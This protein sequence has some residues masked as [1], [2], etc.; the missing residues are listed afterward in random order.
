MKSETCS[1]CGEEIRFGT[2]GNT[3][4]WLHRGTVDHAAILGRIMTADDVADVERQMDLPRT[5]MVVKDGIEVE[6]TYTAREFDLAR[7]RKS[8]K[9]REA[10]D[11]PDEPADLLP[12]VEIECH[13]LTPADLPPRSGCRQV[14]NLVNKT[15]G[16]ELISLNHS[17]GPYI[18]TGG[19]VL[20]ISDRVLLKARG[21]VRFD[22]YVSI[23]VA[24]WR[25]G[26][27]DS[28]YIGRAQGGDIAV[29]AA[30]AT[31]LKDWIKT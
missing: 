31:E 20:S 19:K 7:Y 10:E 28:A 27:F 29:S 8:K 22:G 5:R 23:A 11:E 14:V 12:P 24:S 16:W 30:N 9:Y 2:R 21:L 1:R 13:P 6:E 3:T 17:R 15:E 18:G 25:D 26:K 4:G